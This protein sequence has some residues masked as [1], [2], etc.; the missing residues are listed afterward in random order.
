MK[1]RP[2]PSALP[3]GQVFSLIDWTGRNIA[4]C[5]TGSIVLM[6]VRSVVSDEKVI[7]N[8]CWADVPSGG[9]IAGDQYV[10]DIQ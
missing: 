1:H 3:C 9:R 7:V 5:P 10:N 2:A 4:L 8:G 6:G